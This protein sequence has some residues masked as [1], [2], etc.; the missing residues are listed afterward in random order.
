M[1]YLV[2]NNFCCQ[3]FI[4]KETIVRSPKYQ[5]FLPIFSLEI[6]NRT[7]TFMNNVN[8]YIYIYITFVNDCKRQNY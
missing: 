2:P 4:K 1:G 8:S 5:K 3:I 7:K 6:L